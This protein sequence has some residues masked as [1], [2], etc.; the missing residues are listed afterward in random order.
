MS[1]NQSLGVKS[2]VSSTSEFSIVGSQIPR[3]S[4][5]SSSVFSGF[6][7]KT[8]KSLRRIEV[9][10]NNKDIYAEDVIT[11][12]IIYYISLF[13]DEVKESLNKL[14]SKGLL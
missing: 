11:Q 6:S 9:I 12:K 10:N 8:Q 4:A 5:G 2:I 1:G 14:K 7:G 3:S 13:S